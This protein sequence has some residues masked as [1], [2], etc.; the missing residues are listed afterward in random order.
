[1]GWKIVLDIGEENEPDKI[2]ELAK[3]ARRIY[4]EQFNGS[5]SSFYGEVGLLDECDD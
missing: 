4:G 2:V 3:Q 1:M 5:I